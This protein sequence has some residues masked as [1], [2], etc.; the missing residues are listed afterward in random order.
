LI[1]DSSIT[2]SFIPYLSDMNWLDIALLILLLIGFWKGFL[3]GFFVELTS[4][5]ALVAAIYGSIHFSNYAGDWFMSHTEWE[6]STI[7]I[8][9]FVIT[10]IVI[11]LVVTYAGRLVTKLVKTV[12]LSFLNKIAGGVFGFLK[13]AFIA[14]VILMFINSAAG[15]IEVV[16][17]EIKDESILYPHVEPVAPYLLPKILEEADNL[18][19]RIRGEKNET[20]SEREPVEVDTIY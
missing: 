15:E 17:R 2:A 5:I 14:S 8:A 18:D 4:L 20:E 3:N 7:T 19:R 12:Q 9:S 10:F 6:D 13:L 11:I 16:D 1:L